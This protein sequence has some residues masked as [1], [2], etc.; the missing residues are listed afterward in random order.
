MPSRTENTA[1]KAQELQ[2]G[3]VVKYLAGGEAGGRLGKAF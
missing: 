1:A 3:T 2:G